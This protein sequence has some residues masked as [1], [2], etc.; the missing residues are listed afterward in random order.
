M[1]SVCTDFAFISQLIIHRLHTN[2]I[3]TRHHIQTEPEEGLWN[4]FASA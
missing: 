4:F 2:P 1:F 3:E